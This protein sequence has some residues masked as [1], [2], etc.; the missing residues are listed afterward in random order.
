MI[1]ENGKPSKKSV[2]SG[3]G[4][5]GLKNVQRRLEILLPGKYEIRVE[6]DEDKYATIINLKL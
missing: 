1:V 5:F 3:F 4:G 6:E 2:N